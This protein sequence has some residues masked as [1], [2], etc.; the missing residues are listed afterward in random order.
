MTVRSAHAHGARTVTSSLR[1]LLRD[2]GRIR[3]E[4]LALTRT[5]P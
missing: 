4:F 3:A 5:T 1:G 2:D